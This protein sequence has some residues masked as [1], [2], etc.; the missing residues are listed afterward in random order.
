M[1][2]EPQDIPRFTPALPWHFA[3]LSPWTPVIQGKRDGQCVVASAGGPWFGGSWSLL[4]M[5][6]RRLRARPG[7]NFGESVASTTSDIGAILRPMW[8]ELTLT[9]PPGFSSLL[10]DEIPA[11]EPTSQLGFEGRMVH[12]FAT[13]YHEVSEF[14]G[15]GPSPRS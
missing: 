14:S 7:G 10:I 8:W 15:Q 13:V 3:D 11:Y 2:T 12:A 4:R 1:F 5:I 6:T 9:A